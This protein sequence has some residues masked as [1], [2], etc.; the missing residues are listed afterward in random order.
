MKP[1]VVVGSINMDLVSRTPRIPQP[2]E[3]IIGTQFL[4]SPPWRPFHNCR[5]S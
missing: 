2:G 1:I 4:L 5:S 3:K